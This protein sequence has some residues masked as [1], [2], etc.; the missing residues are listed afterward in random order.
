MASD[1]YDGSS[2]QRP[3]YEQYCCENDRLTKN[4]IMDRIMP[5]REGK[6]KARLF[7]LFMAILI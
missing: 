2:P 4:I 6:R 3:I 7:T 1:F 5:K